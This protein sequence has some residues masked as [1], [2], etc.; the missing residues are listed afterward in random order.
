[1]SCKKRYPLETWAFWTLAPTLCPFAA[2]LGVAAYFVT[3]TVTVDPA[4][5]SLSRTK[6]TVVDPS[7]FLK[8]DESIVAS[9]FVGAWASG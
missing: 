5:C 8:V 1:M 7:G 4:C 3:G 6:K 2:T 9:E